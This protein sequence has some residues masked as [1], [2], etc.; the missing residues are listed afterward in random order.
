MNIKNL[1]T[2][3][4]NNKKSIL[5]QSLIT[6]GTVLG[7]VIIGKLADKPKE[8]DVFMFNNTVP[9]SVDADTTK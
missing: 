6:A 7:T 3:I 9:A 4:Q 8:G 2:T 1:A 5:R